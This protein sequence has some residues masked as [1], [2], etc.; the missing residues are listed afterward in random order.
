TAA[1][2][3]DYADVAAALTAKDAPKDG[4]KVPTALTGKDLTISLDA[5]GNPVINGTIKIVAHDIDASNGVIH[6]IDAV[7]MPPM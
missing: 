5:D 4:I 7:L 2:P 3:V 6:V 1:A